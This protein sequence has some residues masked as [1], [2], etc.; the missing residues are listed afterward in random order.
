MIVANLATYPPRRESLLPVVEALSAQVA[1]I[2]LVLNEY[3]D[4]PAELAP[5]KNV[6]PI[7]PHEDTKDAGKF[8]PE[9]SGTYTL[10]CD[11]DLVFPADFI[12]KTKDR[13]E[14]MENHRALSG[15]HCS[16][17]AYPRLRP[18]LRAL[19]K[20]FAY[21]PGMIAEYR[22]IDVFY[23]ERTQHKIVDQVAT[24][25]CFTPSD[26]LPNYEY[27]RDS[28]KF[29]DVRLAKWCFENDI[30]PISLPREADWLEAIRYEENIWDFT[31]T[32]PRHVADEIW[33]YAFKVKGRGTVPKLRQ[34]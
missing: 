8:Y 24:N 10:L 26:L 21:R 12:S 5:F 7:M 30:T 3:D 11:D 33:T 28:Q 18:N 27:M 4:I 19:R 29:V 17:Y 31:R 9:A 1:Q 13:F 25:C 16:T 6:N 14:A 34:G 15:Y 22:D 32:N 2:N 23:F 20:F